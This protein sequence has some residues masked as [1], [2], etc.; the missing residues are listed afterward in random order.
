M[1]QAGAVAGDAMKAL[2]K[3]AR[4]KMAEIEKH[5]EQME[6]RIRLNRGYLS[7][8][9]FDSRW[10]SHSLTVKESALHCKGV[11]WSGSGGITRHL[12]LLVMPLEHLVTVGLEV[13][14]TRFR[15]LLRGIASGLVSVIPGSLLFLAYSVYEADETVLEQIAALFHNWL[16][17]MDLQV[18]PEDSG[19]ALLWI[20][21]AIALL[22]ALWFL[23]RAVAALKSLLG[24]L[25]G[26]RYGVVMI[27]A[28]S[29]F[30]VEHP[31]YAGL[32]VTAFMNKL[33][34]HLQ[35]LRQANRA[36]VR[37]DAS[38]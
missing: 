8:L 18:S 9:L 19:I 35:E 17:S 2:G 10:R 20:I 38:E 34:K 29:E 37:I 23:R 5:L 26:A 25:F 27:T 4:E 33:T 21:G 7:Y 22:L 30:T 1:R 28:G 13:R 15:D 31:F 14:R 6:K 11:T 32:T 3:A 16:V 12:S 36:A 24:F